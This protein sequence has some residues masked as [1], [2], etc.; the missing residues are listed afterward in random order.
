[1]QQPNL[2]ESDA[3]I[4]ERK[5]E[6]GS[7]SSVNRSIMGVNYQQPES[8]IMNSAGNCNTAAGGGRA[9]P[10][11]YLRGTPV[12]QSR[13]AKL[14]TKYDPKPPQTPSSF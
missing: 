3:L 13:Q 5:K 4:T 9:G 1:M 11:I 10:M 7:T 14:K 2:L 6:S 12:K 8:S